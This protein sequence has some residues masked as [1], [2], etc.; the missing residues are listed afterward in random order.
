MADE[1]TSVPPRKG[2]PNVEITQDNKVAVHVQLKDELAKQVTEAGTKGPISISLESLNIDA[3][4]SQSPGMMR[5]STGCIS[6]PGG[7]SC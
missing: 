4:H 2:M 6:N 7:P 5:A 1:K 3:L